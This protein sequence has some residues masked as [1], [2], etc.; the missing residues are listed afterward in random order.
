MQHVG[1]LMATR[2][3]FAKEL[4]Q[5]LNIPWTLHNRRAFATW[6]QS[7]GGYANYNPLNTT[8]P[9]P[10]SWDYNWVHV[11]EYDSLADGLEATVLTFKSRNHGYGRILYAMHHNY[12]AR[13]T[14]NII[15]STSWGTGKTLMAQVLSW[16]AHSSY[17]LRMLERK[18]I[19]S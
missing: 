7:E 13:R 10:G 5:R 12:S 15:G 14:V 9:M 2:G 4:C 16:I 11:Q 19:P 1:Q 8:Q 18:P 3:G 17:V 6:M